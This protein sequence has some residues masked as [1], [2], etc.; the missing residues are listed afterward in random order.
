MA[1]RAAKNGATGNGSANVTAKGSRNGS[2]NGKAA[3]KRKSSKPRDEIQFVSI[4]GETRRRYLNYAMSVIMSRALPDVRDGL[5]PVQRRIL[6]AMYG[7]MGLRA[8]AKFAKS[9]RISGEVTGKFHPH[10][11]QAAYDTMVRLAQTFTL[12]EPLV[13]GQGN[14]GS[15]IGL[16]P[17]AARYT[18]AKLTPVSERLMTEL[19]MD[20]VDHR[21]TYSGEFEEPV[22][23]PAQFPNLLVNGAAGIAVGMATNIPPHNLA[24]TIKACLHLI[25]HPDATVAQLMKFIKGP[26][27]PLGGRVITDR[28][29]LTAAYKDGRGSI[30]TRAE[31]TLEPG[32]RKTEPSRIIIK[33]VPYG[34]ETGPL[35]ETLGSLRDTAKLPQLLDVADESDQKSGLRLVVEIKGG[36]DPEVVMAYLYKNT[37]LEQNFGYNATCLVPEGDDGS[38]V[39][40]RC[41]LDEMLKHFLDFRMEVVVRRLS[42]ELRQ[43][44]R[45]IHILDGFVTIFNGLDKALKLIRSSTGKPDA[46]A[47]LMKAFPLDAEQT[48][49]ILMLALYRIST[50]EIDSIR[51]ELAEKEAKADGIRKLLKSPKKLWALIKSELQE[52]L[53]TLA[54]GPMA[55]RRTTLGSSEEIAE[56]DPT[57]Y[58]VKENVQVVVTR[59]GWIKRIG[60]VSAV[61]K[62]RVREGDAVLAIE[63]ASTTATVIVFASDGTAYTLGVDQIPPSTGYGEPLAKFVKLADGARVVGAVTT[64]DRFTPKDHKVR[65]ADTPGPH[66]VI[67]TAR[68]QIMRLSIGNFR[69]PSTK[70]GRR[71]CRLRDGDR[72]VHVEFMEPGETLFLATRTA[73]LLHMA[74][75]DVPVLGNPGIGVKGISLSD[76]DEVL[77]AKRVARPSD[78]LRAVNDNGKTM[79]M[80]QMKYRV[81]GRGGKGVETSK[82]LGFKELVPEPLTIRGFGD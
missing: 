72:V 44:E 30:K 15:V 54:T 31:W 55:K 50:L 51:E 61:D 62:L 47:K 41:S 52:L 9:A 20:T 80:G 38:L 1:K 42:F 77:G 53:D 28:R 64:D 34:V 81:T 60:R 22:V 10:G 26:D 69:L 59:D 23:L 4:S 8:D 32:K 2:K 68:G 40:K 21:P 48:D 75:K 24:E 78:V 43:L 33:S 76:R 49:A 17:A 67:A 37:P 45:R 19:R 74:V 56:F 82:R 79:S 14:F 5:K 46:A 65:G 39:P 16:P 6:F 66:V 18:E 12:R 35:L 29:D 71:F 58:I 3:T 27:F 25:D 7:T 73:R 11:D 70:S 63:P 36:S 57:A 13:H